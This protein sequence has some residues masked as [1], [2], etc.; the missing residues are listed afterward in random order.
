MAQF[1]KCAKELNT[2]FQNGYEK[3]NTVTGN[4]W[5][6]YMGKHSQNRKSK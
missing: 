4:T 1:L 3:T 5:T 6:K 2:V